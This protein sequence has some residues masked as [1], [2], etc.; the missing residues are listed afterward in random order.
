MA[1]DIT[2]GGNPHLEPKPEL[3]D[4]GRGALTFRW[5]RQNIEATISHLAQIKTGEISCF[6]RVTSSLF[7]GVVL[8]RTHLNLSA[9]RSVATVANSLDRRTNEA[10]EWR[11]M[12]DYIIEMCELKL[13]EGRPATW[14][15]Y[16]P[17]ISE[18]VSLFA[19]YVYADET[20]LISA[21]GGTGK[22][23]F[24][25]AC[26][27]SYATG[28]EIIPGLTVPNSGPALFLDWEGNE[29]VHSQLVA[30]LLA[31][32]GLKTPEA[33]LY[34]RCRSRLSDQVEHI[35]RTVDE[36]GIKVAGID[37]VSW[38][39]G[40]DAESMETV[41]QYER[42]LSDIGIAT[43]NA[44]H[45]AKH[46]DQNKPFGSVFWHNM[47]RSS[48]QMR[49]TR[50]KPGEVHIVLLHRKANYRTRHEP[51]AYRVTF[52][53]NAISFVQESAGSFFEE[54]LGLTE[55]IKGFLLSEPNKTAAEVAE[56]L[57]VG[58]KNIDNRLRSSDVFTR[59][60]NSRPATWAVAKKPESTH[61]VSVESRTDS[62]QST[63]LPSYKEGGEGSK[64]EKELKKKS[65]HGAVSSPAPLIKPISENGVQEELEPW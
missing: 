33:L 53:D 18:P 39:C 61:G 20:T 4:N 44:A 54:E 14:L 43:L 25:T 27:L 2:E 22:T 12:L 59:T 47:A 64:Q 34:M 50:E 3:E 37:S 55:R 23:T 62:P 28:A 15:G 7:G 52:T 5:P 35:H 10:Y 11:P 31:G 49:Q 42:A 48:W 30:R 9:A 17:Q 29:T 40:G 63:L 56:S 46:S 21:D 65:I 8:P 51:L 24:L 26:L 16:S 38:A 32:A 19:P 41:S 6:I 36:Y 1:D 58:H 13:T 45:T 60:N 57:S